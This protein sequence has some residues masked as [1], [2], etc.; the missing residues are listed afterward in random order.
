MS[1]IQS[2][3][4]ISSYQPGPSHPPL[5]PGSQQWLPTWLVFLL[6]HCP[7]LNLSSTELPQSFNRVTSSNLSQVKPRLCSKPVSS[8]VKTKVLTMP[9]KGLCGL[10]P[11]CRSACLLF[12]RIP[13]TLVTHRNTVAP[14]QT[15]HWQFLP[16]LQFL[17]SRRLLP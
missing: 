10:S 15:R 3:P 6:L 9:S 14:P 5:L 2:L 13:S 12:T 11:H 17:L 4:I 1:G 8:A 7:L 16:H